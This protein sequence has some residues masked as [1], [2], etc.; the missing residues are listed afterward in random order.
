MSKLNRFSNAKRIVIKIG[1]ALLVDRQQGVKQ[2]WLTALAKDVADLRSHGTQVLLVSSGAIALGR[3]VLNL[4]NRPL[5]LDESQAAAAVGQIALGRAWSQALGNHDLVAGQILLTL[6]DTEGMAG[7]RSYLNARDTIEKLLSLDAI[8]VINENDTIATSE[9]RYGDNDRLGARVATMVKA[10]WLVLLSDIDGLYTAPP[11]DNPDA[12]LIKQVDE[13]TPEIEA[14]AGSAGS[15]LSS[16]GMVTKIEA[17]KIA[18]RA[19]T[20]MVIASGKK[21]HPVSALMND[22]SATWFIAQG[23]QENARKSWI[24]GQLEIQ[25]DIVIDDGAINALTRGKS[26]LPAGA[27]SVSGKFLRGDAVTIKSQS[28]EIIGHGLVAFDAEEAQQI[29]G[30]KSDEIAGILGHE[31]RATLI[32]RDDMA[33]APPVG[34]L[35]NPAK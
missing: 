32:H 15:E 9:I 35:N 22:E 13:I 2:D 23:V 11:A 31:S 25:G 34:K 19:G 16:G 4:P 14:M 12:K 1:S 17:G 21:L 6:N 33:L 24:S 28:G 18:M 30:R 10:D 27:V 29:C 8:P 5:K 3:S 20:S 7:R 26:L